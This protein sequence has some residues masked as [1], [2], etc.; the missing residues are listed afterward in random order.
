MKV[1]T[2]GEDRATIDLVQG[3]LIDTTEAARRL[4]VSRSTLTRWVAAGRI[5][6]A[7]TVPGYRGNFLFDPARVDEASEV[8]S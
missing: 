1:S 6:P 7:F 2:Y 4:G 8:R 3:E 5:E